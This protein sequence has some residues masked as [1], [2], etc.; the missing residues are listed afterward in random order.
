MTKTGFYNHGEYKPD[1][2]IA[3]EYPTATRKATVTGADLKRGAVLAKNSTTGKYVLCKKTGTNNENIPDAV[4]AE[5]AD[6]NGGDVEAIVYLTGMFNENALILDSS[7]TALELADKLR[8]KG[9][10]IKENQGV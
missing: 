6:A 1:N 5:D 2:L 4:L 8:D 7:Y 3:G 9:M 10:F